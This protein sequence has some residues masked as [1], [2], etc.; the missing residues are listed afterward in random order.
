MKQTSDISAVLIEWYGRHFRP[1]PWRETSDPYLIWLSEVILQQTRVA[2]GLDYFRR[3]ASRF[4]DVRSL[5]AATEDEVLKLWQ[6][7]GYYSRARSLHAAARRVAERFD[8]VFP[9]GYDDVR[10]LPGVGDYTAS[11]VCS[12]A[13]GQP[14][15][16]VDGNVYRVLSRLTDAD[17]PT[18]TAAG[19]RYYAERARSLLDESR[20]GLH[21]QAIMEF[22]ALQCVP[23]NPDCECCPLRDRCLS[24]GSRHGGRPSSEAGEKGGGPPLLQ[25]SARSL[26]RL[27]AAG[28]ADRPRYLAQSVRV[29]VDRDAPGGRFRRTAA[30]G[31]V[32]GVVRR[33]GGCPRFGHA[34]DAPACAVAP[35]DP[36][37]F[38]SG[39]PADLAGRIVVL[40]ESSF[41]GNIPLPC[42][43]T[44]RALSGAR[45]MSLP[46]A[47]EG[48]P[49]LCRH[50]R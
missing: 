11:A 19:K 20:P 6:G 9:T 44:D 12:I 4:P 8:G 26:R 2:Q 24:S 30:D 47:G 28:E 15:A 13:Y 27:D 5:A 21:N 48:A 41:V 32:A 31:S 45:G 10:S 1:L 49:A 22:G 18:D 16:V 50:V 42:L 33:G 37:L 34:P 39:R 14:C 40:S 35:C 43:S 17:V 7:L 23:A 25:L 3:F 38:L 36:C 46:E 29:S